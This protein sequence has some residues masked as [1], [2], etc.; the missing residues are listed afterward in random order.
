MNAVRQ[1]QEGGVGGLGL[2]LI[3]GLWG[4]WTNGLVYG[5]LGGLCIGLWYQQFQTWPSM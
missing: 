1:I 2:R 5:A 4:G 3:V